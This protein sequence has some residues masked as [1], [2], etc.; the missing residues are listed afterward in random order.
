MD[1]KDLVNNEDMFNL[2]VQRIVDEVIKRLKNRPKTALV[3]FTGAVIGY[4]NGLNAME[5][6]RKDGWQLKVLVTDSSK[7]VLDLEKIQKTLGVDQVYTNDNAFEL[8]DFVK[9]A[10]AVIVPT[11]TINT[12]AKIAHG[13][14]DTPVLTLISQ[15][16]MAGK[17]FICAIDGADPDDEVRAQIGMGKVPA[18]YRKVLRDNLATLGSFGWQLCAA[19]DLYEVC[20]EKPVEDNTADAPAAAPEPAKV[21]PAAA[22]T[23]VSSDM[24]LSHIVSRKDLM[25]RKGQKVVKVKKDAIIT[26]FAAETAEAYGMQLVRE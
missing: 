22:E 26:S 4:T 8:K 11:L 15:S 12:A 21:Q 13:I 10:D 17:S 5:K 16:I 7:Q 1:L 14:A 18:G 24:I 2:L 19:A 20:A 23:P 25:P 9:T 6:L 3:C